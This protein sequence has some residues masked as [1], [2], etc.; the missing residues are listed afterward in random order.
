MS[1][2]SLKQ[3]TKAVPG[4][5]DQSTSPANDANDRRDSYMDESLLCFS[6]G[7]SFFWPKCFVFFG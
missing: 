4:L 1:Y 3:P 6:T 5:L 7:C 2:F